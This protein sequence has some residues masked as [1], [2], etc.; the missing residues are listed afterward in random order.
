LR[1]PFPLDLAASAAA[2]A[3]AIDGKLFS[4]K[5]LKVVIF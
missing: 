4:E 2:A 1:G 3:A 5:N